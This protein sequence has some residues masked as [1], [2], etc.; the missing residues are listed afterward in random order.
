MRRV[1]VAIVWCHPVCVGRRRTVARLSVKRVAILDG[2]RMLRQGRRHLRWRCGMAVR[3][4][5][6]RSPSLELVDSPEQV[7]YGASQAG[8]LV[9]L[10]EALLLEVADPF[11]KGQLVMIQH[12]L[13]GIHVFHDDAADAAFRAVASVESVRTLSQPS[14]LACSVRRLRVVFATPSSL[15]ATVRNPPDQHDDLSQEFFAHQPHHNRTRR[16]L[17]SDFSQ[18]AYPEYQGARRWYT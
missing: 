1:V 18:L 7:G 16:Q 9:R 10:L 17:P 6:D 13:E 12:V 15:L 11:L 3:I 5:D 14:R 2:S 8:D 4:R